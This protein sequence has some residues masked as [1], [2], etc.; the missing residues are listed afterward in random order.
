MPNV[1]PTELIVVM[2]IAPLV[3]GPKHLPGAGRAI[4][5]GINEFKAGLLGQRESPG[6]GH[7]DHATPTRSG[8]SARTTRSV[9]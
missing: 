8:A 9:A 3:L 4:G 6:D 2:V 1:G 7:D 5:C